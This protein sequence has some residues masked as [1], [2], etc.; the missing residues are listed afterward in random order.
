MRLARGPM[1]FEARAGNLA[2]A[3]ARKKSCARKGGAE[4]T[5]GWATERKPLSE[6]KPSRVHVQ[7]SSTVAVE[8]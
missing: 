1:R 8:K 4:G 5:S 3:N 7:P 6:E 2:R